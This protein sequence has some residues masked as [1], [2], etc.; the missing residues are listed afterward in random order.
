MDIWSYR[1]LDAGASFDFTHYVV[2]AVD[3]PVGTVDS[4]TFG[5]GTSYLVVQTP[6]WNGARWRM[7]PAALVS[8]V[9]TRERR[10]CISAS[11]ERIRQAPCWPGDAR[12][13]AAY[14]RVVAE[15][16]RAEPP[17]GV[18]RGPWVGVADVPAAS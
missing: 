3:G 7:L 15:H 1:V 2:E 13:F 12:S 5:A 9:D 18:V 6:S 11:R 16:F 4:A 8:R 17:R 10:L 14:R